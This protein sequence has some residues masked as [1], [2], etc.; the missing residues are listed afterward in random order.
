MG[1]DMLREEKGGHE[2]EDKFWRLLL[3]D[4]QAVERRDGVVLVEAARWTTKAR[5]LTEP[6][7][8]P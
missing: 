6:V 1:D 5:A 2:N 3:M 4:L 8:V 7:D